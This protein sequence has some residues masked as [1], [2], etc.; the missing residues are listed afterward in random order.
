MMFK[1]QIGK[2][3]E[4]YVDDMLIKSKGASDYVAHL[5]DTFRI[6][7][8]RI[9]GGL[10]KISR[11]YDQPARY[12]GQ[13]GEETSPNRYAVSKQDQRGVEPD[14]KSSSP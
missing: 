11:V 5:T 4:V 13:S 1:E 2:T 8:V 12:R 9:R 14:R 6:L 3:I 10:R 7:R